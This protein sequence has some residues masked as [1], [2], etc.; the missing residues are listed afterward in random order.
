MN[1][2]NI[3]ATLCVLAIA[4][5]ALTVAAAAWSTTSK[6]VTI[7]VNGLPP[8]TEAAARANF[9]RDVS[10]FQQLHPNIKVVPHE[11]FMDPATFAA[12]LAGGQLENVFYVYFTDPAG[13]I[14]RHQV[15]DIT[16]AA[17]SFPVIQQIRPTLL[18]IFSDPSGKHLYGLPTGNYSLGLLYNRSLF[19]KAGLDPNKP[20][21][22]WDAV[23]TDAKKIAALGNNT[24]GYGEYSKSNTGGW[25]FTAE[26]YSLGGRVATLQGGKWKA[27][28]NNAIGH[29]V[30]N[31]LHA[32]RWDD[33]SMGS[34]QFLEWADLLNMMGAGTLGMQIG[35]L[36]NITFMVNQLKANISNYGFGVIP[37]GKGT[38]EGG[39]GYMFNKKDSPDQIKAGLT[40]LIYNQD[41]PDRI[42]IN[43][44][45]AADAGQPVGLPEPNLWTGAAEK[46]WVAATKKYS[47]VP[48]ANYSTFLNGM[49]NVKLVPEP[50]N[51]QQ[52]YAVLDPVMQQVLTNKNANINQLLSDAESQVNTILA[53]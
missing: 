48:T 31:Q 15:A 24:V 38:L 50:P 28:F 9:L 43:N 16:K 7:T 21:T 30:L 19:Q 49:K 40:W 32:M 4:C 11:G 27:S 13:L 41:N 51:A 29:Q 52:I 44:Q 18:S 45:I 5:A 8:K 36:D 26:M 25:H 34:K 12:R 39:A 35:A 14:D 3:R 53:S 20:P 46:K 1:R 10:N 23:R 37:G 2:R 22:T 6:K 42:A 17:K 33:N 47:N